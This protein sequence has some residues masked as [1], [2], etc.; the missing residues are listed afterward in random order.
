MCV[1]TARCAEIVVLTLDHVM[2]RKSVTIYKSIMA[3]AT[4]A[5]TKSLQAKEIA[6]KIL[7]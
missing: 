7:F 6:R 3:H 1:Y 2:E 5:W 4:A